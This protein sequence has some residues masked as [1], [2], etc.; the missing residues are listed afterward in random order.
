MGPF[1]LNRAVIIHGLSSISIK[2]NN[3]RYK[4]ECQTAKLQHRERNWQRMAV[5]PEQTGQ[6]HPAQ[7]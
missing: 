2:A 3:E 6:T 1:L 4:H 7:R 5:L